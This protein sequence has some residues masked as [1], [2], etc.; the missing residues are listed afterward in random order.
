MS[1]PGERLAEALARLDRINAADPRRDPATGEPAELAY[2]RRRS[3]RL[4]RLEPGASEAL[5]LAVRAQHIARWRLPREQFEAGRSGYKRWR[6]ACARMHA[7][8]AGEVLREVGY[9]PE[10]VERVGALVRKQALGTDPEAQTL[11]DVACLVFLEH[12][13]ADFARKHARDRLVD[14]VR[15]TWRKMSP[16]G[17]AAALE[18][19][20]ALPEELRRVV[21]EAVG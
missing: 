17:Q 5:E 1:E 7:E 16:R 19:A 8:V 12:S 18:L 6:S 3:E 14:I 10:L 4:A 9:P 11:E 21:E 2:A 13:L 20:P 15:K